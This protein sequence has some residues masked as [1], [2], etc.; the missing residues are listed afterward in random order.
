VS[1]LYRFFEWEGTADG[2][3]AYGFQVWS[4]VCPSL[5]S[6]DF[7]DGSRRNAISRGYRYESFPIFM[8]N[9]NGRNI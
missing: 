7:A 3:G 1:N 8:G 2:Y 5:S 9:A 4:N 6:R